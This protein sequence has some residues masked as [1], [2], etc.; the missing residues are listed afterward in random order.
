MPQ[1]AYRENLAY[2]HDAAH[3]ALAQAAAQRLIK[4]LRGTGSDR[5]LV[6]DLGCGSGLL[7]REVSSAGYHVIGIDLSEAMVA[8]ARKRAPDAEFFVGSFVSFELPACVAV[9]AIG[10]VLNYAF[11]DRNNTEAHGDLFRRAHRALVPGGL[12][13]F[14]VAGFDR[15][16]AGERVQMSMEGLDWKIDAETQLDETKDVLIR[17]IQSLR[18]VDGL[19]LHDSETHRL[20]L[21]DSN[22]MLQ[23]LES[24]GFRAQ[25]IG[26]YGA[27]P[28][29]PGL[30]GFLGRK[31]S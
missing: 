17:R 16:P 28:L 22:E 13:M 3:S 20:V 19:D 9:T 23:S 31:P 15:A 18:R 11:D 29:P 26:S 24:V 7:A 27:E 6:V 14:D 4:E 21:V 5:G 1:D 2:I 25:K 10:E 30:T 8:I 12:L